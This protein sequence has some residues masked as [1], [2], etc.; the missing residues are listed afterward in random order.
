[1]KKTL[2]LNQIQ[3]TGAEQHGIGNTQKHEVLS[4]CLQQDRQKT[5]QNPSGFD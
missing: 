1:M 5:M 4:I 2:L 3:M